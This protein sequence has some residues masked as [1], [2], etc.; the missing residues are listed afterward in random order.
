MEIDDTR[1]RTRPQHGVLLAPGRRTVASTGLSR[2]RDAI[3]DRVRKPNR[4][5]NRGRVR[6]GRSTLRKRSNRQRKNRDANP[7]YVH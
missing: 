7:G 4:M 6:D 1:R 2:T 3:A 5:Q